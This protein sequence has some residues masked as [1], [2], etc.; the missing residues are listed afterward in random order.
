ME[1]EFALVAERFKLNLMRSKMIDYYELHC[2]GSED[3]EV[4]LDNHLK[5]MTI[6]NILKLAQNAWLD[7]VEKLD[8]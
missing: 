2:K 7:E 5:E 1:K 4:V 6:E 8:F 3:P